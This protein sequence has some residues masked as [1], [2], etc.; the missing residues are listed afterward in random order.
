MKLLFQNRHVTKDRWNCQAWKLFTRI[1]IGD[2]FIIENELIVFT[3]LYSQFHE[4]LKI[5]LLCRIKRLMHEIIDKMVDVAK[6][7]DYQRNKRIHLLNAPNVSFLKIRSIIVL[8]WMRCGFATLDNKNDI[9]S[10]SD[11]KNAIFI[12]TAL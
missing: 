6:P 1:R 2:T 4:I 7:P 11:K 8:E 3:S 12:N 5:Q 10:N 9:F